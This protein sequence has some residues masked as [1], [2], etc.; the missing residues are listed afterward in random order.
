MQWE[1]SENKC[2]QTFSTFAMPTVTLSVYQLKV[3]FISETVY[4]I[5]F[6]FNVGSLGVMWTIYIFDW[7][8]CGKRISVLSLAGYKD[9]NVWEITGTPE[10]KHGL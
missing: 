3:N 9:R 6:N 5:R 4:L 1:E 7:R 2:F 8:V 10:D